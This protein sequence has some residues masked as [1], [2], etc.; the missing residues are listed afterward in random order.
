MGSVSRKKAQK[1]QNEIEAQKR[2]WP[3]ADRS[4]GIVF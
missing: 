1:A 3:S 2:I 4:P